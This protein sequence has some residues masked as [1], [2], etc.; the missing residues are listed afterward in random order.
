MVEI[1]RTNVAHRADADQLKKKIIA[2][3][4]DC[5]LTF[6]LEDRDRILRISSENHID[7]GAVIRILGI[8]GFSAELLPG[9][10]SGSLL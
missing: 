7:V 3:I 2:S 10:T 5:R 4:G 9:E 6:D 8:N 1:I